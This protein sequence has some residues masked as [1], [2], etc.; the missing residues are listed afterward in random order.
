MKIIKKKNHFCLQLHMRAAFNAI[1]YFVDK[2]PV[3]GLMFVLFICML[4]LLSNM[5][6][7]ISFMQA[8]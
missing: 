2:T 8:L 6:L 5:L 1:T 3:D 7:N 4:Y